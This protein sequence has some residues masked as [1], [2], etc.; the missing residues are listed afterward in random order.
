MSNSHTMHLFSESWQ[1]KIFDAVHACS[2]S[3]KSRA[4]FDH[5]E[6]GGWGEGNNRNS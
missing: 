3:S 6:G 1:N 2:N 5:N 4:I